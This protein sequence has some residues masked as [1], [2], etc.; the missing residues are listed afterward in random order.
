MAYQGGA[1]VRVGGKEF[2]HPYSPRRDARLKG[3]IEELA[4]HHLLEYTGR[5]GMTSTYF[6]KDRGYVLAE[7]LGA[8]PLA[9]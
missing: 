3:A 4:S 2:L 6:L 8:K 7:E 5:S 1:A 9:D